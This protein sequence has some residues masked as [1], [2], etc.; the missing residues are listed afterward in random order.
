MSCPKKKKKSPTVKNEEKDMDKTV[1][2]KAADEVVK[3][4]QEN[5]GNASNRIIDII[6]S[7]CEL[8][9]LNPDLVNL[10]SDSQKYHL[11]LM[12]LKIVLDLDTLQSLNLMPPPGCSLERWMCFAGPCKS[13]DQ[14]KCQNIKVIQAFRLFKKNDTLPKSYYDDFVTTWGDFARAN[15][16]QKNSRLIG[17]YSPLMLF[18]VKAL[19]PVVKKEILAIRP[20]MVT[21][22][23]EVFVCCDHIK[24]ENFKNGRLLNLS[25][26]YINRKLGAGLLNF[27]SGRK[28]LANLPFMKKLGQLN[29]VEPPAAFQIVNHAGLIERVQE[30]VRQ[31][32]AT[33]TQLIRMIRHIRGVEGIEIIDR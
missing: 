9:V 31:I 21:T 14:L 32:A 24:G 6:Q 26:E 27:S 12:F 16:T 19:H 20:D 7:L 15:P 25:I 2:R 4:L 3:C 11:L 10:K 23:D 8:T 22:V 28:S 13:S 5:G 30:G 1:L 17:P 18:P 33:R 29:A